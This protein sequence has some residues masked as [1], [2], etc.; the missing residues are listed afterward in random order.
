MAGSSISELD[1]F[2]ESS[3]AVIACGCAFSLL[4]MMV[5]GSAFPMLVFGVA[6][7]V[8]QAGKFTEI[9]KGDW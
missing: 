8:F 4:V 6:M 3:L 5:C 1:K 2:S 7:S 9:G